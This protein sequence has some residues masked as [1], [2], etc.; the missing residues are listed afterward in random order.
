MLAVSVLLFAKGGDQNG[1]GG[2][3]AIS[4]DKTLIDFGYV[5]LDTNLTLSFTVTNTGDGVLRFTE[6]PYIEIREGC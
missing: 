5:K 3:P 1:G 2:I 6:A 4:A